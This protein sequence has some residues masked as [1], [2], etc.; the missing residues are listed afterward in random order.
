MWPLRR[1]SRFSGRRAEHRRDGGDRPGSGAEDRRI[2][3]GTRR[4]V[5]AGAFRARRRRSAG[6]G[7]T[8]GNPIM[9]RLSGFKYREVARRLRT[10]GWSYD[11]PGPGSHEV[12][13]HTETG[14]HVTLPH[15]A[16]DMAEGTLR[17]YS[18]R[19]ESTWKSSSKLETMSCLSPAI[20]HNT[21]RSRC[22]IIQSAGASHAAS[23]RRIGR[24]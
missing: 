5:A 18:G 1:C 13:R 9:G 2:V 7:D 17:L 24:F 10:F 14:R 21:R 6:C 22:L 16:R 12:W 15:H 11:R 23:R 8:C 20:V 3:L 19:P 4:P